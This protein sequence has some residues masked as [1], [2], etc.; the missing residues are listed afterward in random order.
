MGNG[1]ATFVSKLRVASNQANKEVLCKCDV[2]PLQHCAESAQDGLCCPKHSPYGHP[3]QPSTGIIVLGIEQQVRMK[4]GRWNV[5]K[6]VKVMTHEA[7]SSANPFIALHV[8]CY[9][10]QLNA[11][12]MNACQ[13][14]QA[15][16][17]ADMCCEV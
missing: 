7:E 13:V 10:G 5:C 14:W 1:V 3:Q 9:V 16:R 4:E 15:L 12:H 2:L 8:Q 6:A 17:L 11:G